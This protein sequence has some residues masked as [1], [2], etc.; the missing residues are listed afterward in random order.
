MRWTRPDFRQLVHTR[1]RRGMPSTRARTRCRLGKN[2]RLLCLLL[3]EMLW[4]ARGPLPQIS[5]V[6]AMVRFTVLGACRRQGLPPNCSTPTEGGPRHVR[7]AATC[8][9]FG[10]SWIPSLRGVKDR[11]FWIC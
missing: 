8:L 10:C 2:R 6:F 1:R 5:H 7:L 11:Y 9:Y 4:P 3:K